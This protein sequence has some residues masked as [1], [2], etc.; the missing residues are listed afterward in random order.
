MPKQQFVVQE[1][2]SFAQR[3]QVADSTYQRLESQKWMS[4]LY[5]SDRAGYFTL[6]EILNLTQKSDV[7]T[8]HFSQIKTFLAENGDLTSDQ[9]KVHIA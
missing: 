2:L 5:E 8:R 6:I 7:D 9:L 3:M 4:N 1:D